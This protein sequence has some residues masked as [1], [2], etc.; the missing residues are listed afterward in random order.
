MG[1]ALPRFRPGNAVP[2]FATD[3]CVAGTFVKISADKNSD[4]A[5]QIVTCSAGDAVGVVFGVVEQDGGPTGAPNVH[6]VNRMVNVSRRGTIARVLAGGTIAAGA[7]VKVG[8]NGKA[9]AQGGTGN[10][11]GYACNSVTS[12]QYCEVDLL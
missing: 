1:D 5:Y 7:A 8:A 6:S 11:V 10:I 12:G 9:V 4:G 2:A 3:A